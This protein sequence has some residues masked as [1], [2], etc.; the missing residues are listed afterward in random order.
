MEIVKLSVYGNSNIGVYIFVNNEIALVPP[1]LPRDDLEMISEI[2]GVNILEFRV[3]GSP[4]NGVFVAG[5]DNG[6]L[7]PYF[8]HS[9]EIDW[10]K[11]E[12]SRY[13]L[14]VRT[15]KS[16]VTAL[17]NAILLNNK[18]GIVSPDFSEEDVK[19]MVEVLRINVV[20]R[21]LMN[22]PIP[23]SLGVVND[24]GGIVH[25]DLPE[26]EVGF[27]K[28]V[29]GVTVEKATVNAGVPFIKSGLIANNRGVIVGGI[30]TGPEILRIKRG[31]GGG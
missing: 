21:S 17:G 24:F 6:I 22:L 3:A 12:V 2:L 18:A 4:L 27:V 15:L 14:E 16:R 26:D 1:G 19:E 9:S 31:F 7:L 20:R 10:L 30:T 23:G 25:P 29:L 28:Q 5:N 11:K 13:G 8:V